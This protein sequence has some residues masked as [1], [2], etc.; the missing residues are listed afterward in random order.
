[1]NVL[2]A[3]YSKIDDEEVVWLSDQEKP[4]RLSA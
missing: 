2:S 1:M 4:P 3:L